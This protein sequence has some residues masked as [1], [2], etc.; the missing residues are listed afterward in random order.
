MTT[1]KVVVAHPSLQHSYQLAW[2]LHDVGQLAAFWSATPVYGPG[3]R[4]FLTRGF[5]RSARKT[6]IPSIVRSHPILFA[7]ARRTGRKL[8]S[9]KSANEL[10]HWVNWAFDLWAAHKLNK[11]S[12]DMVVGYE[13]ACW[14]VFEVAK[15]KGAICILDAASVHWKAA[16]EWLRSTPRSDPTWVTERKTEEINRSDAIL[17]CSD[18]AARTYISAGVDR[19]RIYVSRLGAE[20]NSMVK[21]SP[22]AATGAPCR[23]VFAGA[24]SF[25]KGT[26]LLLEVFKRLRRDGV[27]ATLT[28]VGGIVDDEIWQSL[29]KAP[30]IKHHPFVPQEQLFQIIQA[31][32]C[33]V[34]PS[35]FDSFGMVVAEA[36]SLGVPCIVSDRVGAKELIEAQ[37][38]SGWIV[39]FDEEQ[40]LNLVVSL[41]ENRRALIDASHRACS[42]ADDLSWK[43]YREV[44]TK[45]L[46]DIYT[47]ISGG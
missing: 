10:D 47:Q 18:F 33:L 20:L 15:Q 37:P 8:L 21:R 42:A 46:S 23:F 19:N 28:L 1:L 14:H 5:Y 44:S 32:D 26:D 4:H 35:R 17:T 13:T 2:A 34:L 45:A 40:L 24:A 31:H 9:A 11:T 7:L 30:Y 29:K 12:F 38:G 41:V 6:P 3:A 36:L 43:S 39:S 16:S 22:V 27:A 25:V